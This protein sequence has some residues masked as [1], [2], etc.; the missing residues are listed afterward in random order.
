MAN[1][2]NMINVC[3]TSGVERSNDEDNSSL[4]DTSVEFGELNAVEGYIISC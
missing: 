1:M 2:E 4:E 3:Q